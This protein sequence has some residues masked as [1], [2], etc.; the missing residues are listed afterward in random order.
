[1]TSI[2]T[3]VND[4]IGGAFT[5]PSDND[6]PNYNVRLVLEY[7]GAAGKK[8]SDLTDEELAPFVVSD[9]QRKI[10]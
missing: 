2:T 7:C 1:M 9:E 6:C 10:A 3:L 4:E 5:A 8:P